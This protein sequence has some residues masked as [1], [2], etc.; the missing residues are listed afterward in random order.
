M[1]SLGLKYCYF[2]YYY[3]IIIIII[4]IIS[5]SSIVISSFRLQDRVSAKL[6]CVVSRI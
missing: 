2:N 6:L 5:S 4:I 1:I 3:I